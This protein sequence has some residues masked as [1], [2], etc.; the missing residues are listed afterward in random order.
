LPKLKTLEALAALD[1]A[2]QGRQVMLRDDT[3][4]NRWINSQAL[5]R[6][7]VSA[8]TPDPERARSAATRRTGAVDRQPRLC[9]AARPR[10]P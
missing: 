1:K 5:R 8:A 10:R 7:G 6:A 2:S 9:H 3:Y 4:H